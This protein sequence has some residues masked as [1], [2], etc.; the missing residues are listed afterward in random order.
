MSPVGFRSP[1]Q[2]VREF[3]TLPENATLQEAVDALL[4]TSQHDFPVVDEAGGV[5]GVLTAA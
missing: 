5:A 4:A 3:H 1:A 2:W